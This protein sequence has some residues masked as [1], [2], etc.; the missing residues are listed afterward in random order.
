ME[1]IEQ[2][3]IQDLYRE[4]E[5]EVAFDRAS[6]TKSQIKK[7]MQTLDKTKTAI[8]RLEEELKN[9][10]IKE[11]KLST[12]LNDIRTGDWSKIGEPN[13]SNNH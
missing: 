12:G 8:T 11:H 6:H 2:L 3:K 13:E 4:V 1:P 9:L 10:K 7:M 5:A